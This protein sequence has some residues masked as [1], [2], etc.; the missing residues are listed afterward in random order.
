MKTCIIG[1]SGYSGRELVSLLLKHPSATLQRVTSRSLEGRRVEDSIPKLRGTGTE[2]VFSNPSIEELCE[3][4]DCELFFLALPHGTA[5]EF[6]VPLLDAGKKVIDLSADFRLNSSDRYQEY[7]GQPHPAPK[8]LKK[9]SYGLPELYDLSW[10]DSPLI[11]SPGCYPT[12]I[13][14]PLSSLLRESIV[15]SE[16]II[17]NSMSGVSGAGRNATEKLLYCERNESAGAYGLPKHR[18]LSEIE[19]Q[20]SHLSHPSSSEVVIS[21]HPHLVPMNRGICTT[22]SAQT[23]GKLDRRRVLESWSAIFGH[24]PFVNLLPE[25][26]FPD[27][28]HVTGTNRIDLSVHADDRTGRYVICSAEDNLIKGAGGQAIQAMNVCQRY[29]ESAGLL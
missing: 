6:A 24:R 10:D 28:K 25:G 7:Y 16:G 5:A 29:D 15:K 20:L 27:V 11:A 21:F 13:L 3:D 1:A 9:A 17:A 23:E 19:E 26:E 8:W 2:L 12:S 22:I 14:I 18:H 4:S